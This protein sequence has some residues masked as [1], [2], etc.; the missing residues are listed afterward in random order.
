MNKIAL[1]SDISGRSPVKSYL[2]VL[3]MKNDKDSKLNLK[4]I[5][6]YIE[7][8]KEH[9]VRRGVPVVKHIRG[10]IWEL[11]PLDKHILFFRDGET[12]VLLHIFEKRTNKTPISEIKQAEMEMYD[13][14]ERK[15]EGNL[16]ETL[17]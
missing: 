4:K 6:S 12:Y 7:S 3:T 5:H 16:N 9:G 2:T 13:Y 10:K 1:Y 15:E 14:L 8:L 17:H 11:R